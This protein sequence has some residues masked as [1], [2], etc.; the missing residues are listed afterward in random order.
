MLC[1]DDL[2]IDNTKWMVSFQSRVSIIDPNWLKPYSDKEFEKLPEKGI[3]KIAVVCPSFIADCLETLEE[4]NIRGKESFI[5]SGGTNFQFIPCLN[6][7]SKFI[8]TL[9]KLVLDL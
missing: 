5:K 7:S 3:K 1:A 4:I 8:D 9:E 2:R 6:D